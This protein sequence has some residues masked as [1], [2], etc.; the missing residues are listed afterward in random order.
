VSAARRLP[1]LLWLA[2]IIAA[3]VIITQTRF[4]AD[5]S[6]FLPRS[7]SPAQQILVDQMQSGAASRLL[8]LAIENAPEPTLAALSKEFGR[9]L[10]ADTADFRAVNN[11]DAAANDFTAMRDLFW[12]YRYA[13]SPTVT[14]Q[15]FTVDGLHKALEND[16]TLLSSNM[17]GLV[18]ETLPGDPTGEILTLLNGL[19]TQKQPASR[20]GV[21]FSPD[22]KRALLLAQTHNPGFDIATEE[23]VLAKIEDTFAAAQN[24]VPD[25][26]GA[27]LLLSGPGVFAVH[28]KNEMKEDISRLSL[29]AT[30]LVAGI[31]LLTYRS[32]RI[33]VLAFVPV[34]SGALAGIAA[35]SL[36]FGFVHG[37]T[38]GF[39]VT[40]IGEAV[41]YAIYLFTQT[42]PGSSA[43][44]T[45]PRI[46]PML[47][48]GVLI[49]IC[50]FSAMLFSSFTGFAQLGLF[51]IT[52]LVAAVAVTRWV[53]P[54]L[55][56]PGFGTAQS[57]VLAPL[58][59]AAVTFAT[60]LRW[61]LAL[62]L[63]AAILALVFHRA[64][65]W[66]DDLTS[67]SPIPAS[68]QKL[69]QTLRADL[70]APDVR[71]LLMT[72]A[73][74]EQ[75]ALANSEKLAALL[76]TLRGQNLLAGYDAPSQ[77]LPSTATQQARLNALPPPD[78][79]RQRMAQALQD[80]PFLPDT[81]DPFIADVAS[82]KTQP[83]L[84]RATIEKT[85]VGAKLDALLIER[86]GVWT[87]LLSLHGVT[88][89]APIASRIA[90][91]GP[92]GT[93]TVDLKT[94]SNRLLET[95]R[96]EA[97]L[98]ALIGSL[99]I[100][101]LL[102]IALRSPRR[103]A[104]VVAPLVAAVLVTT[105]ILTAGGHTLSIFNLVG[106][107]LTVAVGSNYC[108]F[109]ERQDWSDENAPRMLASLVLANACTIIGFGTL[110]F[111]RLPVLHDIGLTVA[112]GTA[113][114]LVSAAIL[115]AH[116]VSERSSGRG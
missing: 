32:P 7:P 25:A 110:S 61:L 29:I 116:H 83:P 33:L 16:L 48:L 100:V 43:D 63:L 66:E 109:V 93:I 22:G 53:L 86:G 15:R 99:V 62:V 80:T 31:L 87:A 36:G 42:A 95:Y 92:A 14:P 85:P 49:S 107:L 26:A 23:T 60:K 79:L 17:G 28:T 38:L 106:L 37:I 21:W 105:A 1:I 88:D 18:K 10:R 78:E 41:D 56:A 94:E 4:S 57:A 75:Q 114:S 30:V 69:D 89:F 44:T 103:V 20:D 51:S 72:S 64:S 74:D 68:D 46:W 5:M 81:F 111:A 6:A 19:S 67:L 58:L 70:A 102:A 47:Q 12:R 104:I 101:A 97:V 115:T 34:A 45:L 65:F 71:Y 112:L 96:R 8:L 3:V 59:L 77:Y 90:E 54:S 76:D 27:R 98:L 55:L 24:A 82:A 84:D 11:G 35:V 108:I 40:L 73:P 13:L 39:G 91:A 9:R 52:G 50:G 113:L 2:G